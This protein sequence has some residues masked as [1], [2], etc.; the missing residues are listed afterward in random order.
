MKVKDMFPGQY[1]KATDL[2]GRRAMVTISRVEME[3][4]GDQEKPVVYFHG[5]EKGLVLNKTNATSIEE[6]ARTDE[7]DRWRGVSIVLYPSRTD[8]QGKRV[9]CI[10]VDPPTKVATAP[11][12]AAA[13]VPAPVAE[14]PEAA[15]A[16]TDDDV[17]F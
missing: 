13:A 7:T 9:D 5:K 2:G 8:F 1:L 6:I 4:I 10:R 14:E 11:A 16:A 15:F 3:D 17:P 12:Q